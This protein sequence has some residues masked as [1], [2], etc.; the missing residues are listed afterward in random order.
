MSF[1]LVFSARFLWTLVVLRWGIHA[2]Q[3]WPA[4]RAVPAWSQVAA[5]VAGLTLLGWCASLLALLPMV[6]LLAWLLWP[7]AWLAV[8][9]GGFGMRWK[10][11][12]LLLPVY[13][14]GDVAFGWMVRWL[15][16]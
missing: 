14:A 6:G 8:M 4:R 12:L 13:W 15:G 16:L 1:L 5:A 7:V 3:P 11:A 9:A 10:A 2:L